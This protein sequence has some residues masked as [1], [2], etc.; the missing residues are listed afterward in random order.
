MAKLTEKQ[1]RFIAEY[2]VSLN[3]TQAALK[4]G[5]SKKT[6]AYIGAENLRKPQL[7]AE[8]QKRIEKIHNKTEITQEKVLAEIAAIAFANG[9]DFAK[10]VRGNGVVFTPTDELPPDKLPAIASIEENTAGL[11]VRLHDKARAL[12]LLCK[13]LGLLDGNTGKTQPANNLFDAIN[14]TVKED[15]FDDLPELQ[16]SAEDDSDVVE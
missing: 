15:E 6:A 10:I 14:N 5:Y 4:A 9:A 3:A 7:Q 11:R 13:Y 12:E 8:I 16:S 1:K 2:I